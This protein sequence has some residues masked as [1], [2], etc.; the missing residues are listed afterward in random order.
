[1]RV[2]LLHVF[3]MSSMDFKGEVKYNDLGRVTPPLLAVKTYLIF[4]EV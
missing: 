4:R 1:M 2:Y 3:F